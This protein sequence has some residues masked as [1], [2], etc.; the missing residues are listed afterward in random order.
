[1]FDKNQRAPV[2]VTHNLH[3][4]AHFLKSFDTNESEKCNKSKW[5]QWDVGVWDPKEPWHSQI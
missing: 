2:R 1:M 3:D 5:V 4:I